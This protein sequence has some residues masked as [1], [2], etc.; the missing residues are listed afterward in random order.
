[1][2]QT[3]CVEFYINF[4]PHAKFFLFVCVRLRGYELQKYCDISSSF[5]THHPCKY[6]PNAGFSPILHGVCTKFFFY[7]SASVYVQLLC[8]LSVLTYN[9]LM[10]FNES[11]DVVLFFLSSWWLNSHRHIQFMV[12]IHYS[13]KIFSNWIETCCYRHALVMVC[14]STSMTHTHKIDWVSNM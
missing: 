3:L 9:Q 1:M 10:H 12:I 7:Y 13:K 5:L 11:W 8:S 14:R 2:H 4:R 6:F